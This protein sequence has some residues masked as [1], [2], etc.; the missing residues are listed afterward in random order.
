MHLPSIRAN[1]EL[2]DKDV[3]TAEAIRPA[4]SR[5]PRTISCLFTEWHQMVTLSSPGNIL[6]YCMLTILSVSCGK[7]MLT[8]LTVVYCRFRIIR[9]GST[10]GC[11]KL[12][13]TIP[14]TTLIN[15]SK[16]S[17]T[18]RL[19]SQRLHDA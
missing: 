14:H 17:N 4:A 1:P 19:L 18:L 3:I 2:W 10:L 7:C 13:I 8:I 16:Y 5:R 11:C 6:G 12:T 9:L 15:N